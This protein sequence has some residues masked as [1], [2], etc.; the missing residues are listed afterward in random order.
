[1]KTSFTEKE[2]N[3]LEFSTQKLTALIQAFSMSSLCKAQMQLNELNSEPKLLAWVQKY[4]EH[5][6]YNIITDWNDNY[7]RISLV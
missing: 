7:E 6:Q 3:G 2:H 4:K 5:L 1:M